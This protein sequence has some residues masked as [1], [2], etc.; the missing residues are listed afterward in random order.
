MERLQP[1]VS[2]LAAPYFEGARAGLLRLQRCRS[3]AAWQFYPRSLCTACG[4][5]SL[6][7]EAASGE[8]R[9]ASF[10]VVRRPLSPAYTAPYIVALIDL[11]EGPRMMSQVVGADPESVAVGA[12]VRVQFE[13]W[14][15]TVSL[16][17][18]QLVRG[19]P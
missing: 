3:C 18:F 13:A 7:W 19:D 10:T 6:A 1:V 12:A 11:A 5:R 16:P 8:G 4:S 2:G 9:I 17:V 15:D 14:S